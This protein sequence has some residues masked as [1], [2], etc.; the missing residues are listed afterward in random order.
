VVL[1]VWR[2][3]HKMSSDLMLLTLAIHFALHGTWMLDASRRTL[4]PTP[5]RHAMGRAGS[6][7]RGRGRR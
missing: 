5:G 7:A 3:A 2:D 6:P 4:V 1:Q